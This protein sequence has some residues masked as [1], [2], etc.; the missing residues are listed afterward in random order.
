MLLIA[1]VVMSMMK[2]GRMS[3]RQRK[4]EGR[5]ADLQAAPP[6]PAPGRT[7]SPGAP[8]R[9]GVQTALGHGSIDWAKTFQAAKVGGVQN[10]FVEQNM[11]LTKASV[12][13]LKT[14]SG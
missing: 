8:V 3:R 5:L 13:F 2:G 6:P 7:P 14:F 11:E 9:R 4:I 10:Y 12:A 1:F